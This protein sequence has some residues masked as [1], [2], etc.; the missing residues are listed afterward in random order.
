MVLVYPKHMDLQD[1]IQTHAR[2]A[3]LIARLT[4]TDKVADHL[5]RH[6]YNN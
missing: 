2:F 3:H 5:P 4:G 6:R 1:Q